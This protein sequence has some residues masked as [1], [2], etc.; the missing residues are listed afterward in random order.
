MAD[1]EASSGR[2]PAGARAAISFTIDNL[3][4]AADI[5][6]NLWPESEPIG[7]H[8]SVLQALPA[9]LDLLKKYQIVATFFIESWNIN[10]YGDFILDK[11]A[12]AGH[13]IA[14]HGWQHEAWARLNDKEE[15]TN[16]ERSFGPEGIGKWIES[17]K[18][19]PYCGFRPPSGIVNGERT[20]K[21]CREFGLRYLSPAGEQAATLK[22]GNQGDTLTIL[23]FKWATVDAYFYMESFEDLRKMKG[24]YSSS[25]QSAEVLV[26]RYCNEI[27]KTIESGGFLSLL[28]HPFLTDSPERLE[29]MESVLKYMTM[30]REIGDIW[31]ARCKDVDAFIRK[32]PSI[33]GSDPQLDMASWR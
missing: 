1:R 10:V 21:M 25:P 6:R 5:N 24:E 8:Y 31:L 3:G 23:P 13:E 4:E 26:Q 12:A 30:K 20:L 33:V 9:M 29:A 11:I 15:R 2:W 17:G 32:Q 18:C 19:D 27:D 16:F 28:F 14:W 7:R 22:V